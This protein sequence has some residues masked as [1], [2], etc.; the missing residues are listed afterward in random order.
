MILIIN[1]NTIVNVNK[2]NMNGYQW[3]IINNDCVLTFCV[4]I[5][6]GGPSKTNFE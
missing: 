2:S 3:I 4:T 1:I 5:C 6:A